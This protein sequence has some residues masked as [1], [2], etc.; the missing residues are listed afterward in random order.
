MIDH[1][2]A[3]VEDATDYVRDAVPLIHKAVRYR[4]SSRKVRLIAHKTETHF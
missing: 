3:A 1:I 2:E 4:N